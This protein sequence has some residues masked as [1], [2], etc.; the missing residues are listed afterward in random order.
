MY[1]TDVFPIYEN[2]LSRYLPT[3]L[4]NAFIGIDLLGDSYSSI[5]LKP[6]LT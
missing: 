5:M 2:I 1:R 4:L 3:L 6:F